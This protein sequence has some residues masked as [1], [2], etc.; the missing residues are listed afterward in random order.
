MTSVWQPTDN[1]TRNGERL[2]VPSLRLETKKEIFGLTILLSIDPK[3][4]HNEIRQQE[5][6]KHIQTWKNNQNNS[7]VPVCTWPV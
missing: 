2:N 5:E 3:A 7:T 6:I 4:L 1:I